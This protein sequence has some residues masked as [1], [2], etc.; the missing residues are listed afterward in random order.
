MTVA[1]RGF[2]LAEQLNAEVALVYVVD[3]SIAIRSYDIVNVNLEFFIKE[4]IDSLKKE[5]EKS[6]DKMIET[7]G[8]GREVVKFMPEGFPRESIIQTSN[9]WEADLIVIGL[10]G[11]SGIGIFCNGK[12]F[13]IYFSLFKSSCNDSSIK[14]I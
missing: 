8:K 9:T 1:K 5:V 11:K 12:Y 13:S 4:S 7:Y 10:H 2:E 3:L 14:N 6:L